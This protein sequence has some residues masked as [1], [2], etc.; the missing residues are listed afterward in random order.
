MGV[1][2]SVWP[3][4][5]SLG[6]GESSE[7]SGSHSWETCQFMGG[8]LLNVLNCQS[9]TYSRWIHNYGLLPGVFT[10]LTLFDLVLYEFIRLYW[11]LLSNIFRSLILNNKSI[12]YI[13]IILS[14]W[15]PTKFSNSL[16]PGKK[17]SF[18][19]I[20]NTNLK[21]KLLNM[22]ILLWIITWLT[23]QRKELFMCVIFCAPYRKTSSKSISEL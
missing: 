3:G 18:T 14:I 1:D 8:L 6:W 17:P 19:T 7:G 9:A 23:F 21:R 5:C 16:F 2:T 10:A 15:V 13:S 12:H 20:D 4:D 11:I 22:E